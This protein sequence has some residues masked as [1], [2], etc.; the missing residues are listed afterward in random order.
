MNLHEEGNGCITLF[1]T[2][3]GQDGECSC[4]KLAPET[5]FLRFPKS[6]ST[7][8]EGIILCFILIPHELVPLL[9]LTST[10]PQIN[11]Y[12]LQHCHLNNHEA[13]QVENQNIT[14]F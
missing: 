5:R 3:Q 10:D 9:T 4:T 6:T 12:S 1:R 8:E 2:Y 7:A 13:S 11:R 14:S